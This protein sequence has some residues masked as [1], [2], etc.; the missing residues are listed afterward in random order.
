MAVAGFEL[1]INL[2]P[3]FLVTEMMECAKWIKA[4]GVFQSIRSLLQVF[5]PLLPF[6]YLIDLKCLFSTCLLLSFCFYIVLSVTAMG[7][8][9]DENRQWNEIVITYRCQE[10]SCLNE[11]R[12]SFLLVKESLVHPVGSLVWMT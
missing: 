9:R 1:P 12:S 3:F 8:G 6:L 2:D 5:G 7:V 4:N 10:M 11:S